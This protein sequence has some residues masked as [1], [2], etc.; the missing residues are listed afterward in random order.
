MLV[1]T[2]QG[3][4]YL[5][6]ERDHFWKSQPSAWLVSSSIADLAVV[7]VMATMGVLMAPLNPLLIVELLAVV[8]VYLLIIDQFKV[9]LFRRFNIH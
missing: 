9:L 2:G 3:N 7:A 1:A 6:R 8:A 4:V 5:I